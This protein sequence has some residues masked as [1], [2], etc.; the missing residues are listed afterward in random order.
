ML[1]WERLA[2]VRDMSRGTCVKP[3]LGLLVFASNSA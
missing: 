1:E 3:T 2:L